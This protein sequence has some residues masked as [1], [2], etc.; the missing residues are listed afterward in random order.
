MPECDLRAVKLGIRDEVDI[1]G[2]DFRID[3]HRRHDPIR[4]ELGGATHDPIRVHGDPVALREL[5]RGVVA[6]AELGGDLPRGI[7]AIGHRA[8]VLDSLLPRL[9]LARAREPEGVADAYDEM[10]PALLARADRVVV[11]ALPD[12]LP[13]AIARGLVPPFHLP[14]L[15][16]D[17]GHEP[18]VDP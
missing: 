7:P 11:D 16:A 12:E 15:F 3:R 18:P 5:A 14:G 9:G 4:V 17:I 6:H 2:E 1:G 10:L 8:V 13:D